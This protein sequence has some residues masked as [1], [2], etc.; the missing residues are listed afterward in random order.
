MK[1]VG[2]MGGTFNPIHNGHL[3]LAQEA[4]E[5]FDLDEIW[6][7][8]SRRQ[9]HKDSRELPEDEKRLAMLSA[10]L[11]GNEAFRISLLEMER[12]KELTYSY[13]TMTELKEKYPET[14]F[15][16]IIGADSLFQMH[17]WYRFEELLK[18]LIFLAAPRAGEEG[19]DKMK[20]LA[21]EY[22][23]KY[24]ARIFIIE[25]PYIEISSTEIRKKTGQ[26]LSVKYYL[27]EKVEKFIRE[28]G[29][30]QML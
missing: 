30:Y 5:Q 28:K 9:P 13:D 18:G 15:F 11:E 29:L 10:A 27:P 24:Q 16:F 8:P 19:I 3:I 22:G 4:K 6:F 20:E 12:K 1:K 21:A 17:K 26:G 7:L 2:I 23:K 14:E 25:M